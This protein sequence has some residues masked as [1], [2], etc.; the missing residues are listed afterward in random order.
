M[1]V[2]Y[3]LFFAHSTSETAAPAAAIFLVLLC[4]GGGIITANN[5]DEFSEHTKTSFYDAASDVW[6]PISTRVTGELV[7]FSKI[8]LRVFCIKEQSG[9]GGVVVLEKKKKREKSG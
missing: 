1:T 4:F 9:G 6:Q 7:T 2:P 5:K 3:H 8:L